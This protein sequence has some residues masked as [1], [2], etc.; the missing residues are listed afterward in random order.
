M[1]GYPFVDPL[2]T[3]QDQL[4]GFPWCPDTAEHRWPNRANRGPQPVHPGWNRRGGVYLN[5]F[6]V[7]QKW[8]NMVDIT[9][10]KQGNT[11]SSAYKFVSCVP[12]SQ[13]GCLYILMKF[14]GL[15][16]ELFN[17]YGPQPNTKW[18][19]M[20]TKWRWRLVVGIATRKRLQSKRHFWA[21]HSCLRYSSICH[22]FC[23]EPFLLP[24]F[25][26]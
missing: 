11:C 14:H 9:S 5:R 15:F 25:D 13:P 20:G 16:E 1:L 26:V 8:I 23:W 10:L 17:A 22:A 2:S 7:P 3:K 4:L 21:C 6:T 19:G 24:W 18:F 12:L